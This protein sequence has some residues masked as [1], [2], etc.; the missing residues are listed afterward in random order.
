MYREKE[1][2]AASS[3]GS[4]GKSAGTSSQEQLAQL[5][6][7]VAKESAPAAP[8]PALQP[9]LPLSALD[10]LEMGHEDELEGDGEDYVEPT[11]FEF[12]HGRDS[13]FRSVHG[14]PLHN[15]VEEE[16]E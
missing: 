14:A 1:R 3:K 7:P 4:P 11:N 10:F 9:D 16:E 15:V 8:L 6:A 2:Q 12:D 5:P 13:P